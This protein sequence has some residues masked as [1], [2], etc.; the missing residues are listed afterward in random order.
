[1]R[2]LRRAVYGASPLEMLVFSLS[3]LATAVRLCREERFDGCIALQGIPAAWISMPI[4]TLFGI[5][6]LIALV[7]ADVPGF[8]PERFDRL[9]RLIGWLTRMTWRR[10][11]A[12][13]ANSDSL[14]AVAERTAHRIGRHV[15]T[16]LY[17][18]DTE[19]HRPP[20]APRD[21]HPV[22]FL[23]VGRLSTQKGIRYLIEATTLAHDA[24]RGNAHIVVVG[25]G[26]DRAGLEARARTAGLGDVVTFR[27]WLSREELADC[28]RDASV[29]VLPSLDEGRS[30]A[31]LE[32]MAC[33]LAVIATAIE[34]N[35][36]LV[37][38]GVNG[39][40]VPPR[41]APALAKALVGMLEL[42]PRRLAEMRDASRTRVARF[43]WRDTADRYVRYL[44]AGR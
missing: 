30:Q 9:H 24:L 19:L 39:F 10:A 23:F 34:G 14:R 40:V 37:D 13:L 21:D 2:T 4:R 28:Y 41:D 7:G 15:D 27:G 38:E 12:L 22:R 31:A 36:G 1:V 43:S 42:G 16:V 6:Y 26:E 8:L 3:A 32:A 20:A 11:T 44:E 29:F 5:P 25:D 35:T 17:G 33:G 18:V